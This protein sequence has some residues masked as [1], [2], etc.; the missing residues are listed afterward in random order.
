M[1]AFQVLVI[2]EHVR[3]D[4]RQLDNRVAILYD[5]EEET[6]YYYGTR[7]DV[8]KNTYNPYGG[9]YTY[10]QWKSFS[11][12]LEFVFGKYD[13]VMTVETHFL[14][15]PENDYKILCWDYFS[16]HL[17]GKTLLAAYDLKKVSGESIEQCLDMLVHC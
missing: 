13:E 12:F 11:L 7:N 14:D 3:G 5:S 6:Y 2:K 8:G 10:N 1:R 9:T 17:S 15:I 16:N 4:I